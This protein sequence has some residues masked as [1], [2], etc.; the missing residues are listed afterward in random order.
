MAG[1]RRKRASIVNEAGL[2]RLS[3]AVSSG[4]LGV[5]VGAGLSQSLG[6]PG[7]QALIEELSRRAH[8]PE[9]AASTR[10]S[11]LR[12]DL[13]RRKMGT[14]YAA[15]LRSIFAD[16][17]DGQRLARSRVHALV[18]QAPFAFFATTNYD[19]ALERAHELHVGEKLLT[20]DWTDGQT[21]NAFLLDRQPT[22]PKP[23]FHL[24]GVY[25]QPESVVLTESDYRE[26]YFKSQEHRHRLLM[27]LF[28]RQ[29]LFVGFSL[30]DQDI[31]TLLREQTATFDEW[32]PRHFAIL[33]YD[34]EKESDAELLA[35]KTELEMRYSIEPIFFALGPPPNRHAPLV[36]VLTRATSGGGS[37]CDPADPQKGR[38]G[39]ATS[40]GG[41]VIEARVAS[42]PVEGWY[43][44]R[45]VVRRKRGL[46]AESGSVTFHLHDSFDPATR[47]VRLSR[48][49]AE[50]E[51]TVWGAFTI[52]AEVKRAAGGV[53]ALELDLSKL[54]GAPKQFRE[55]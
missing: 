46:R 6:Y 37:Q 40:N 19:L 55:A 27:L 2:A 35:R 49:R 52:G 29:L 8:N 42:M 53:A 41:Y 4:K 14:K 3:A 18:T 32:R 7:W 10:D 28:R 9:R 30:R 36:D 31:N 25:T 51:L 47:T 39:G 1:A 45:V 24:H 44:L 34:P 15:A 50:L 23:C 33:D 21:V 22:P 16:T 26:R 54:R 13:L 5:L 48:G 12:A 17:S 11:L 43:D 38:W 20:V